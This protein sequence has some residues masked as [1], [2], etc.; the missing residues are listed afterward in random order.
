MHAHS[1][2]SCLGASLEN[3][4]LPRSLLNNVCAPGSFSTVDSSQGSCILGTGSKGDGRVRGGREHLLGHI[5]MGKWVREQGFYVWSTPSLLNSIAEH[6]RLKRHQVLWSHLM[7]FA[8][9]P[10][11][12]TPC[13]QCSLNQNLMAS[14]AQKAA[15]S[16]SKHRPL[17]QPP[18]P[19]P[20]NKASVL[21][22]ALTQGH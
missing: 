5:V 20:K 11:S 10:T 7:L 12:L 1:H 18:L 15:G 8:A 4:S 3:L 21:A 22:A 19:S 2:L 14:L 9:H 17:I 13:L 6:G 16:S